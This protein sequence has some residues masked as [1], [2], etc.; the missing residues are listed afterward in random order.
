VSSCRVHILEGSTKMLA[1]RKDNNLGI[2]KA[3]FLR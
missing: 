1:L 3:K 2:E